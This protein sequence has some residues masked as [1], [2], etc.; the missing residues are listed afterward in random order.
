MY[1]I[2]TALFLN[3]S[4][5]I[6]EFVLHEAVWRVDVL[7][8]GHVKFPVVFG[9]AHCSVTQTHKHTYLIIR[10]K[11]FYVFNLDLI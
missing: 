3:N 11:Y 9:A 10:N 6:T 7:H 1:E 4:D 2:L 8:G 5:I